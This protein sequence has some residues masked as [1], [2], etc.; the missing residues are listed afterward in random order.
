M[1]EAWI[2]ISSDS[3]FYKLMTD[4]KEISASI[5]SRNGHNKFKQIS[6][7]Y[8]GIAKSEKSSWIRI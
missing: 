1:L 5:C 8:F 7:S 3:R 6:S 4:W 2:R